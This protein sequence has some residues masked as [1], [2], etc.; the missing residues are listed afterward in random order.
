MSVQ[1]EFATVDLVLGSTAETRA[2][3]AFALA[4]IK[5]ERQ[6]RR[7]FTHLVYQFPVFGSS[8][9]VDLKATLSANRNVYFEGFLTGIDGLSG[10]SI[11]LLVGADYPRLRQQV[12]VAT[13]YRNKIFHGQLTAHSLSRADLTSLAGDLK[14][15]CS[16]VAAGA[17]TEFGYDGFARN[18][19]QK[20]AIA[21]M[22]GRFKV[23]LNSIADYKAFI[24]TH[25]ER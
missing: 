5:A 23:Q 10:R 16:L 24:A 4:L 1:D 15:W 14:G 8:D 9:V 19:F 11:Q 3:D 17:T 20:S 2:V 6:A 13:G 7:I 12:K 21:N 22:A 25:M 18:S